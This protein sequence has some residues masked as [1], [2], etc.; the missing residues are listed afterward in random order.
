MTTPL[1]YANAAGAA[2]TA[3]LST[4]ALDMSSVGPESFGWLPTGHYVG[5]HCYLQY[6][7]TRVLYIETR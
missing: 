2:C 1:Y 5:P 4:T 6:F 7:T 3:A